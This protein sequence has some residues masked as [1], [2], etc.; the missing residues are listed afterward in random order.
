MLSSSDG[1]QKLAHAQTD[2]ANV[3]R[4]LDAKRAELSGLTAE[5]QNLRDRVAR[6]TEAEEEI[7]AGNRR[8]AERL[9]SLREEIVAARTALTTLLGQRDRARDEL[10]RA[11]A[12]LES[13]NAQAEAA[14]ARLQRLT[15]LEVKVRQQIRAMV[16]ELTLAGRIDGGSESQQ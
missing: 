12:M 2:L 15:G 5:E 11:T 3:G 14:A 13:E 6:S 4:M 8:E 10:A 1:T 9:A 16:E 7:E